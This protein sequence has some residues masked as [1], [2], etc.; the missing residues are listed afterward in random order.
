MS[1]AK[2]F[3]VIRTEES[4]KSGSLGS[5]LVSSVTGHGAA[6]CITF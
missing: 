3:A 5:L 1:E 6:Y 2:Q 4:L